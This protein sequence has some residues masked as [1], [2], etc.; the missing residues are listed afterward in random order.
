MHFILYVLSTDRQRMTWNGKASISEISKENYL[1]YKF[2]ITYEYL[3]SQTFILFV[4]IL[5]INVTII[6][7]IS[8]LEIHLLL[9]FQ[10]YVHG[11]YLN[12]CFTY[13][14][15]SNKFFPP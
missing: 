13:W 2:H 11:P 9:S 8:C 12:S 6:E 15:C 10:L 14:Q 7:H 5:Q 1:N 4:F 3:F